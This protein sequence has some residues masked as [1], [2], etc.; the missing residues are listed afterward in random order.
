MAD[1]AVSVRV[2]IGADS[3]PP[4]LTCLSSPRRTSDSRSSPRAGGAGRAISARLDG[5]TRVRPARRRPV[6]KSSV[7]ACR[8]HCHGCA[9]GARAKPP[10]R[11]VG[12]WLTL[13]RKRAQKSLLA[14]GILILFGFHKKR[15]QADSRDAPL[16][17]TPTTT[18]SA[19]GG[20]AFISRS[21]NR[22]NC[23]NLDHFCL[24]SGTVLHASAGLR[25]LRTP[26][27]HR[28]IGQRPSH[29]YAPVANS[30]I[31]QRHG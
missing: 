9:C 21:S 23:A 25:F 17:S 15:Q 27:S 22:S 2:E 13:S 30:A 31:D 14:L 12:G 28:C 26:V 11:G 5:V 16:T 19:T 10:S 20:G 8:V 18:I 7:G 24:F 4:C 29:C 3:L 1:A 6:N